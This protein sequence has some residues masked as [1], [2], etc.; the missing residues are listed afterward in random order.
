MLLKHTGEI[1]IFY[2]FIF[3]GGGGGERPSYSGGFREE[4]L[5]RVNLKIL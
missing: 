4:L 2:D 5:R 3:L 1:V